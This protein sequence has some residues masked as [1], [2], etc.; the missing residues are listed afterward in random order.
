MK[1]K[2]KIKFVQHRAKNGQHYFT[3]VNARNGQVVATSETYTRLPAM[4]GG[5]RSIARG[6]NPALKW[7][8]YAPSKA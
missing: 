6:L 3:I 2:L 4:R 8:D 1:H 7:E 5:I